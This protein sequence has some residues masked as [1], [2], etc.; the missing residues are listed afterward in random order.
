MPACQACL[1][2][3][4]RHPL[5]ITEYLQESQKQLTVVFIEL[6][7]P[8]KKLLLRLQLAC[9]YTGKRAMTCM[10]HVGLNVAGRSFHEFRIYGSEWR[11]DSHSR[12]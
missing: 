3:L 12:R 4:E 10:K 5:E 1:L 6:G 2:I 8:M 9:Q 11:A 7:L